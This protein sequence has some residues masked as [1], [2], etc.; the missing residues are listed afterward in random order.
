MKKIILLGLVFLVACANPSENQDS[1]PDPL[2]A[3]TVTRIDPTIEPVTVTSTAIPIPTTTATLPPPEQYFKE[4]FNSAPMYWAIL[5]SSGDSASVESQQHD[6]A[7]TFS[8]SSPYTWAYAIYGA[9]EYDSAYITAEFQSRGSKINAIGLV[10]HYNEQKGWYEFNISSDGNY[11]VLYGQ[12]L[13]DGVASYEPIWDD[14]S[15]RILIGD[16]TN[17]VG[18][19]CYENTVQVS[20]NDRIIRKFS[21]EK[22]GLQKGKVGLS[23]ASFEDAPLTVSFNWMEIRKP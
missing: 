19:D 18:L 9:F 23:L 22:Y 8:L 3:T 21:V 1:I 10:C 15:E 14:V 6:S 12:W 17:K 11:S 16:S 2:P 7:L 5:L 4:E 20:I 13:A